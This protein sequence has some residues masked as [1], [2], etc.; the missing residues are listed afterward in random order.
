MAAWSSPQ[1]LA[2]VAAMER[3]AEVGW[4][5]GKPT[6]RAG[7]RYSPVPPLGVFYRVLGD[8]LIIAQVAD[9]RRLLEAP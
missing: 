5:L 1:A 9:V 6:G 2:V 8:Q 3:M 7:V 4:S